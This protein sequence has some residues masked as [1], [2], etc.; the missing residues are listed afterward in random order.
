M[1]YKK[2]DSKKSSTPTTPTRAPPSGRPMPR[3]PTE[4]TP[5]IMTTA[6]PT[7]LLGP[8]TTTVE[9]LD[10]IVSKEYLAS[11]TGPIT[12]ETTS[13]LVIEGLGFIVV[14]DTT[15]MSKE[16]SL[17]GE[18]NID[19]SIENPKIIDPDL[20]LLTPDPVSASDK[21]KDV[22]DPFYDFD[23]ERPDSVKREELIEKRKEDKKFIRVA[24]GL[25]DIVRMG[26]SKMLDK[27]AARRR[28]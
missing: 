10:E 23:D 13:L 8:E 28:N 25:A 9:A 12:P 27:K 2:T 24:R 22:D 14:P 21:F 11:Y 5:T 18:E 3:P 15:K 6:G 16:F 19:K 1:A 4:S 20:K 17:I 7:G 26:P